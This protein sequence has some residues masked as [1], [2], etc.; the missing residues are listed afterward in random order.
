MSPGEKL[1]LYEQQQKI[2]VFHAYNV[3]SYEIIY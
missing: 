3:K 2:A 1:R